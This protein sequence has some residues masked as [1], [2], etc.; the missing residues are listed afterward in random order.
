MNLP[1]ALLLAAASTLSLQAAPTVVD[2]GT[3]GGTY[4]GFNWQSLASSTNGSVL[5]GSSHLSGNSSSHAFAYTNGTMAD[6]GTLGGTYSE[7]RA[8]S[9]NGSVIVGYA[10]LTG[11]SGSHAFAYTNG[12]MAD[13]GTL[14]G[15]YSYAHAV[16]AN[17]SVIVGNADLTGNSGSH[18]FAYSNGAMVDLGTLGGTYSYAR[19]VSANGSVIVGNAYT[20]GD[21]SIHGFIYSNGTMVDPFAGDTSSSEFFGVSAD[22]S[23]AVGYRYTGFSYE[24]VCYADGVLTVIPALNGSNYSYAAGVSADGS[25][26]YGSS[27]NH[28]FAA[29]AASP[30]PATITTTINASDARVTGG[31]TMQFQGGTFAPVGAG[32]LTLSNDITVLTGSTGTIDA[33]GQNIISNGAVTINGTSLT[34]TG[35]ATSTIN[36]SGN[37]SG[38]G[39]LINAGGNNTISGTNTSAGISVTGGSLR[40]ESANALTTTSNTVSSG[41]TM[42]LP[43]NL[44]TA[45]PVSIAGNGAAGQV[46]ALA[47][48]TATSGFSPAGLS[49]AMPVTLTA[50]AKIGVIGSSQTYLLGAID[51]ASPGKT[52]TVDT[53]SGTFL[54]DGGIGS[55]IAHV[56][57]DGSGWLYLR[58][59][60][61]GDVTVNAG[62]FHAGVAGATGTGVT[63]N[64]GASLRLNSDAGTPVD[65][66]A[67]LTLSGSTALQINAVAPITQ[68]GA[69][70]LAADS[71]IVSGSQVNTISGAIAGATPGQNL[72]LNVADHTLTLAGTTASSVAQVTKDGAGVLLVGSTGVVNSGSVVVSDG[73]LTNNG[74]INGVV[75]VT[76][77]GTL[78]G[79][80]TIS[81]AVTINGTLAPGNSPGL[82]TQVAGDTTQATGSHFVAQLGGTTPGNGDGFHDQ[83]YVQAGSF[84]LDP[85]VTLDVRSWVQADGTTTFVPARRD[86]FAVIRASNGIL[87]QFS[88]LT[89]ADYSQWIIYENNTNPADQYG[90]LYGTGLNGDQT[91]AAYGSTPARAAVGASL[92]AAAITPSASS[93]QAHPG[94]FLD[95][96]T[97]LG[98]VAIGLLTAVDADA[99]LAALSPEAYL[100]VGDYALT[101]SRSL[102]DA[103]FAQSSLVKTGAWTVGAGYNRAQHGY[104]G[105]GS[106]GY[107]LSGDTALATVAYDFGPHCSV[108]FFYGQNQGK[109]VAANA[110]VDYRGGI[111]GLTSVGRIPGAYPVT[112]KGAV[113]A[114]ELRFDATRVGPAGAG[115]AVSHHPLRSLGGQFT[116]A[117]EL[118]KD[119][120]LTVSPTLGFVQ[121]RSTTTAFAESGAGANLSVDAMTQDSSRL[122]AG[123]GLTYLASTDLV[124]DLSAAYEHEF[125]SEAG[126]VSASFLDAAQTVPMTMTRAI[127]DRDSTTFGLGASW[128]LDNSTTVRLG[129]EVRGNRELTKDYRYNAS[130]NVRF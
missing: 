49:A 108:G 70:T 80:G 15:T 91:F 34:L 57:K 127:G 26:I 4:S 103:A 74:A 47:F 111:F 60:V 81:G 72:T 45:A 56:V 7:A 38:A 39:I 65:F 109:T 66:I 89:N 43:A 112:L 96:S 77:N 16:S 52:L 5:V 102:T 97:T 24:A 17:G 101:V 67:P 28:A 106:P 68:S 13:L 82:Q 64:A 83:Y 98:Q 1:R 126:V 85:G 79:S 105:A 33:S 41:G 125:A 121:G 62:T 92:W 54:P 32:T 84:I 53:G 119:G 27:D 9:A 25:V 55:N 71:S 76:A 14:G 18:A 59:S 110:H 128:K 117:V 78:G 129:A 40:V 104:V 19:A 124:F 100:A 113:V 2:L 11:N 114:S 44:N 29:F 22:G 31:A 42:I 37:I 30:G 8:I 10:D 107:Q 120:R 51:A 86:I 23:V 115:S 116:A 88:D 94:A 99:Y 20:T 46:G 130:V 118:H 69:I 6:L 123:L 95:G 12:T 61:A 63:V 36:L 90:Y 48:D 3:L 73:L 87:G 122:V 75:T 93:T 35:S 58:A 21:S 50:D